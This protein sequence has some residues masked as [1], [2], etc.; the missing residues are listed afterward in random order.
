MSACTFFGHSDCYE[1]DAQVLRSAIEE[2][3]CKGVDTFYVGNQGQ[4]DAMVFR[5][6]LALEKAYPHIS[7]SV[8]LAYLPQKTGPDPYEGYTVYPEGL[9]TVPKRF[10][11]DRRN[12]WMIE[13]AAGGYCLCFVRHP[14]GGAWQFAKR[15]KA[16]GLTLINLGP[17]E[18]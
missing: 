9:E 1:L 5:A 18:L 10:A 17:A 11:V 14:W 12:R 16:R 6:L 2:L 13:A 4:F 7:V 15:A 3:I 8:V